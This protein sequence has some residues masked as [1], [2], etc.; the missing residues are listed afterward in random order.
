MSKYLKHFETTS[1]YESY[2]GGG[3]KRCFLMLAMWKKIK[4]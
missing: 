1:D 3:G 2:I 4:V